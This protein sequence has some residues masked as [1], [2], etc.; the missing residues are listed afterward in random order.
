MKK[1]V[2]D[3]FFFAERDL[4]TAERIIDEEDPF[5]NII[6]FHCQQAVEKYQKAYLIG[7]GIPLKKTHDLILLNNMIKEIK[8]LG[9]NEDKLILIKQVYSETR[10]HGDIGLLPDDL[11]SVEQ[12]KEF[13]EF[14]REVKEIITKELT[15]N[16]SEKT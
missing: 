2:E 11:P 10:Y 14:A 6:A 13:I 9:I 3:W 7:N 8:D 1:Q 16:S 15:P 12:V 5:T 4:K